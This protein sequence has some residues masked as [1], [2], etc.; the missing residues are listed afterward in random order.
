MVAL[1]GAVVI[2]NIVLPEF[3]REYVWNRNQAKMLFSSLQK[4]YPVGALLFWKTD[5]PPELKNVT[6]LPDHLGTTQI[7]LDGQ[8]RLTTLY[9]L[10]EGEVPPYYTATDLRTDPR[11]LFF[12]LET[13]DFQYYQATRMRD[14]P[15]WCSVV[16]CFAPSGSLEEDINVFEIAQMVATDDSHHSFQLA[17]LFNENLNNLRGVKSVDLPV[18]T[19]PSHAHIDDAIDIFDRV[20]SQGTKLTDAE[21]ALTHDTGYRGGRSQNWS[22]Q[23]SFDPVYSPDGT[24]ILY[25]HDE[26]SPTFGC[27]SL[28]VMNADGSGAQRLTDNPAPDSEPDWSPD[29][30]WI[31][32]TAQM[33]GFEL[34][35]VPASGGAAIRSSA[36]TGAWPF[37]AK[38]KARCGNTFFQ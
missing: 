22:F 7:I 37:G 10:I 34:C 30:R 20:N 4:E 11:D 19:V 38:G 14:N 2:R 6:V 12:N 27:T 3:Q 9:L 28:Q 8:Q 13:G 16:E 24:K 23:A 31:V 29:G 17:Q 32:F 33:G 35:V 25:P 18:Q 1:L 36:N 21:L 15:L 26:Y 5:S